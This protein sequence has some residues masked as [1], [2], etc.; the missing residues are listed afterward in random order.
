MDADGYWEMLPSELVLPFLETAGRDQEAFFV[1]VMIEKAPYMD[2]YNIGGG[3]NETR[4]QNEV[5]DASSCLL[6]VDRSIRT[7]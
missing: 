1:L 2:R 7:H 4:I 3:G 5:T 6:P